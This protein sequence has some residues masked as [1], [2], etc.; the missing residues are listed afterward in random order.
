MFPIWSPG[1]T[2]GGRAPS[3]SRDRLRVRIQPIGR[4]MAPPDRDADK[5]G[6][7]AGADEPGCRGSDQG[8]RCRNCIGLALID[9]QASVMHS[10]SENPPQA[11]A[12]MT[13]I[14]LVLVPL[15]FPC[16]RGAQ[17]GLRRHRTVGRADMPRGRVVL[18]RLRLRANLTAASR[19]GCTVQD[20]HQARSP[21]T[22]RPVAPHGRP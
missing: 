13:L 2:E 12:K 18:T 14:K 6:F 15:D 8:K 4:R 1:L 11:A 22:H 10:I 21:L 17:A 9:R 19:P 20:D 3:I 16:R 7:E 5:A